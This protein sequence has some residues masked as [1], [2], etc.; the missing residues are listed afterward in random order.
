MSHD[1]TDCYPD[2]VIRIKH[3][4]CYPRMQWW[5]PSVCPPESLSNVTVMG[6]NM[7]DSINIWNIV[8]NVVTLCS[9]WAKFQVAHTSSNNANPSEDVNYSWA[10]LQYLHKRPTQEYIAWSNKQTLARTKHYSKVKL[11]SYNGTHPLTQKYINKTTAS[12]PSYHGSPH[13]FSN[14][15]VA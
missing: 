5:L 4:S 8:T 14:Q 13:E 15:D 3:R 9:I 10:C 1:A 11:G 7:S 6:T 2:H 12:K